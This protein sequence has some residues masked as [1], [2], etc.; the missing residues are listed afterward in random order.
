MT[1]E[2]DR[3]KSD[4]KDDELKISDIIAQ[5]TTLENINFKI[6]KET[7]QL[8]RQIKELKV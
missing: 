5:R 4:L 7:I 6:K 3:L 2:V 8:K 1:K